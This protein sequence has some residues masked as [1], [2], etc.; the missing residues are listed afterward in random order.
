VDVEGLVRVY[1]TDELEVAALQG[2]D[3]QVVEREWLARR[4]AGRLDV[5]EQLRQPG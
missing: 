5:R 1:R 4:Y 3:L 2:L